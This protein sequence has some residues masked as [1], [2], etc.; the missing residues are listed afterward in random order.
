LYF[1]KKGIDNKPELAKYIDAI[2]KTFDY[3][4]KFFEFTQ[5]YSQI[6]TMKLEPHV[7]ASE[8]DLAKHLAPN[9]DIEF[10]N[11]TQ[12]LKVVTDSMLSQLFYILIDNS[13]KHGKSVTKIEL[14]YAQNDNQ[15][16]LI[17][18]D[19]GVGISQNVKSHIFTDEYFNGN[20]GLGLPLIK[21]MVYYYGWKIS[22][23]GQEGKGAKFVIL[24]QK[25]NNYKDI[26]MPAQIK[27]YSEET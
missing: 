24:T 14:S 12:G 13:I 21:K 6:A 10:V 8:F 2:E 4:K 11:R 18:E 9:T 16:I 19:N 17:Y 1:L 3:S 20:F 5:K 22:E 26:E 25:S 23:E 7:V 15:T 27:D